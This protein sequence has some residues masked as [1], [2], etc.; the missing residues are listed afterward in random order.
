MCIRCIRWV[1]SQ[2]GAHSLM[3]FR[4]NDAALFV[5]TWLVCIYG[6]INVKRFNNRRSDIERYNREPLRP[7]SAFKDSLQIM[8]DLE[9]MGRLL[10]GE[11]FPVKDEKVSEVSPLSPRRHKSKNVIHSFLPQR[12]CDLFLYNYKEYFSTS[13]YYT[14]FSI[15]V[16]KSVCINLLCASDLFKQS[17]RKS[18]TSLEEARVVCSSSCLFRKEICLFFHPC[19]GFSPSCSS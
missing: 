10:C 6:S 8:I 12:V 18:L 7:E 19:W 13:L 16:T 17:S 5:F 2:D 14:S 15:K 1:I 11:V 4:Y 3:P 9:L